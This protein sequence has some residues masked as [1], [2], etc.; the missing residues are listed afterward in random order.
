MTTNRE[1]LRQI[2]GILASSDSR[3]AWAERIV[4]AIR[5]SRNY[6]WVGLYDVTDGAEIVIIAW[7]GP[8]A[9]A[10]PRFP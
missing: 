8:G 7:S 2:S 1:V 4:A 5:I 10:Y 9:P 6:R 3:V